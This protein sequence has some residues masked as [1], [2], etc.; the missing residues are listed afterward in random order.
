MFFPISEW[1][2]AFLVTLAVE[3]PVAVWLLRS[4]EPEL[5]RLCALVIFANF[6]THP[7]V[8]FIFTQL[9]L[10]GTLEYTVAAEAWAIGIEAV[11]YVVTIRG[12]GLRRALAVAFAANLASFAAGRLI[13]ALGWEI[14]S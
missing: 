1:L 10:V 13:T 3:L 8:W 5:G 7:A 6:V 9:F 14:L 11:F 4:A 12:L 2:P